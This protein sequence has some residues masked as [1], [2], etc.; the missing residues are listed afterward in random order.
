MQVTLPDLPP[1]ERAPLV[2]ALLDILRRVLDRVTEL[3]ASDQ[4]LRDEIALLKGR[5]PRP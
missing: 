2:E 4:Q 3:E 1:D 5:K